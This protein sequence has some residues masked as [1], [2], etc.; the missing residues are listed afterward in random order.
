ME[1]L[2]HLF[3]KPATVA[4]P[5]TPA[6]VSPNYRGEI[7]FDAHKCIGCMACMRDCPAKAI[8]IGRVGDKKDRRFECTIYLD[9][10]IYCAQC[11][12]SCGKTQALSR[13]NHIELAQVTRTELKRYYA[14][15]PL[16]P[17]EPESAPQGDEASAAVEAKQ[18]ADGKE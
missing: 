5:A 17:A 15:K 8:E 11:V 2:R 12:D 10:C 1:G 3:K 13:S 9:R 7:K 14:P 18:P 6:D 4:Y 16:P